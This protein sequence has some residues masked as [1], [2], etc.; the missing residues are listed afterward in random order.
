ML[1]V[2]LSIYLVNGQTNTYSLIDKLKAY[3]VMRTGASVWVWLG[4]V[5][6]YKSIR[7]LL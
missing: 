7:E 2:F 4:H 6:N 5:I 3:T 1:S